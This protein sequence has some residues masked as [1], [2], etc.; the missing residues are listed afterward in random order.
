M[1]RL[2]SLF[3]M[4]KD[5]NDEIRVTRHLEHE[6]GVWIQRE[7]LAML[8]EMSEVLEEVGFKWWKN[9]KPID[10]VKLKE[11]LIDMLHFFLSMCID[12]GM[13]PDEMFD[14]YIEKHDEN[15]KRQHGLSTR[16]GYDV[17]AL[18][19]DAKEEAK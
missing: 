3:S 12:A 5:L 7:M 16:S 6:S 18:A 1:D 9:P 10:S 2:D 8:S 11:E 4:Q 17:N 15:L 14:M 19:N 13:T